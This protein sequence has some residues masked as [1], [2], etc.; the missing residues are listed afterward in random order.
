MQET[1]TQRSVGVLLLAHMRG[2]SLSL[3]RAVVFHCVC[4]FFF[5]NDAAP[6]EIY[7]LPL[8][9]ALPIYVAYPVSKPYRGTNPDNQPP[10]SVAET[11]LDRKSTRLNSSH[12]CISYAVFCLK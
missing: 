4:F 7:P 11:A 3:R 5:F 9:A 2:C 8:P 10:D 1:W 6:P 12:R